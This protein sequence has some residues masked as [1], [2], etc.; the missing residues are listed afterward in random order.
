MKFLE[1]IVL[2]VGIII[3]VSGY[4]INNFAQKYL[5]LYRSMQFRNIKIEE[6]L[7]AIAEQRIIMAVIA[8]VAL[9]ALG[10]FVF[11]RYRDIKEKSVSIL[12]VLVCSGQA[13]KALSSDPTKELGGYVLLLGYLIGL[14]GFT[15][16]LYRREKAV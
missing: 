4:A 16:Q 2:L 3:I 6:A 9:L 13:L 7:N 11:K 10:Y 15:I 5:T 1:R 14:I 12:G 8:L